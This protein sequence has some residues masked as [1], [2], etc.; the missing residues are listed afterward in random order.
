MLLGLTG[1]A[2]A[3]APP[4]PVRD[5]AVARAWTAGVASRGAGLAGAADRAPVPAVAM[6]VAAD[7]LFLR[8]SPARSTL[9]PVLEVAAVMG[10]GLG[11]YIYKGEL[12]AYDWALTGD[13]MRERFTTL[14]HF[15]FDDNEFA[16]NNASHPLAGALYYGFARA[17]GHGPWGSFL[18]SLAGSTFWE[19][20][21][22]LREVASLNDLIATPATGMVLGEVLYQHETFFRR[23]APTRANRY[24]GRLFGAPVLV[25]RAFDEPIP[26]RAVAVTPGGL[27]ADRP[28]DFRLEVDYG[29]LTRTGLAGEP[30]VLDL[31][32]RTE[33]ASAPGSPG[34]PLH[35]TGAGPLTALELGL[36]LEDGRV[37]RFDLDAHTVFTGLAFGGSGGSRLHVGPASAFHVHTSDVD[38]RLL[39]L[40]AVASVIGVRADWV[41]SAGGSEGLRA[42]VVAE[43][44]GDFSSVRP[45][46]LYEYWDRQPIP[47]PKSVL[48]RNQYYYA[49][50]YTGTARLELE[51]RRLALS[52]S[53]HHHAFESLDGR[54]RHEGQGEDEL[55]ISD[56]RS[57]ARAALH[58]DLGGG[59]MLGGWWA[60]TSGTGD[61]DGWVHRQREGSFGT[62]LS[63]RF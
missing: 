53:A 41:G 59:V 44:L 34:A 18:Y 17:N 36:G 49:L 39:D 19:V 62:G 4:V 35:G 27:P 55:H 9:R 54:H 37:A 8:W 58:Y 22:E 60:G 15:R 43:G 24:L 30:W 23:A 12:N 21:V 45:L 2:G 47:T 14:N 31:R 48:H 38:A 7:S 1:P 3:Q 63:F 52:A 28:H 6:V 20:V 32:V 25:N 29:R 10:V 11:I 13:K 50:G 5:S 16:M 51:W 40:Q 56:R 57:Y 61:M 26:P 33:I 42:R 46:A